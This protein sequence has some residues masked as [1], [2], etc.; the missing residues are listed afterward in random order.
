MDF[1]K[2]FRAARRVSTPLV[3]VRTFDARSVLDGIRALLADRLA[4]NALILWDTVNGFQALND[5]ATD[6]ITGILSGAPL[7]D[8]CVLADALRMATRAS[9]DVTLFC[10]MAHLFWDDAVTRQAVWNLR[11]GFKANGNML[12]LL[13]APG[14]ILPPELS[15][16]TLMLDEPLPTREQIGATVADCFQF[17]GL[18]AP[19]PDVI[20]QATDALIGLPSFPVEQSA[21]M[22][23]DTRTGVLSIPELWEHK[24]QQISQ[25]PGL[26]VFEGS[27]TLADIGGLDAVKAFLVSLMNGNEPPKCIIYSDEVEKAFAG[28][29][30]GFIRG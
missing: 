3:C 21:S 6:E 14:S 15:Q 16:D 22:A 27:E 29:G 11:D 23:L 2:Q 25:T 10:S 7:S 13:A 28:H 30:H 4:D 17:A 12:V 24:R 18:P 1:L 9:K 20:A 19:A 26:S 5:R 8:S